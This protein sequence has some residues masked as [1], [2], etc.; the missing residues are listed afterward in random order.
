M[1]EFISWIEL[2]NGEIKYIT[3]KQLKTTR[4]KHLIKECGNTDDVTGHGFIRLYYGLDKN[5]GRNKECT[6]FSKPSN[7]PPEI[8]QAIKNGE[9]T[10][11][12][13]PLHSKQMTLKNVLNQVKANA[14]WKKA[15]AEWVKARAGIFWKLFVNPE[16]RVEVWK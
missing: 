15:R 16:N 8:V 2:D 1:C 10:E 12:G 9:F 7:F 11:V 3:S 5:E 4:G 13:M 6:N 14:E